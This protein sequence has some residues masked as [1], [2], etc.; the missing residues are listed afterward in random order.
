M[1][2]AFVPRQQS[3]TAVFSASRSATKELVESGGERERAL[4]YML[5]QLVPGLK[6]ILPSDNE[7]RMMQ[8]YRVC[9]K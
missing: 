9:I 5:A 6:T 2:D 3:E 7:L 4:L 8:R 1:R